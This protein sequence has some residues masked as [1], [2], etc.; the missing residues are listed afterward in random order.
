MEKEAYRILDNI[1]RLA[2]LLD[3]DTLRNADLPLVEL[4]KC[5]AIKKPAAARGPG[6]LRHQ[7]ESGHQPN[8][9]DKPSRSRTGVSQRAHLGAGKTKAAAGS[10]AL[11]RAGQRGGCSPGKPAPA[12][13]TLR[14]STQL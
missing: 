2:A 11:A 9:S 1:V 12:G 6:N 8:G 5:V 7:H 3:E 13:G 14:P 4:A 10:P